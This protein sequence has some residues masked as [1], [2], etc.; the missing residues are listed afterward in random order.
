M[1]IWEFLST[2]YFVATLLLI[3]I[4]AMLGKVVEMIHGPERDHCCKCNNSFWGNH[5]EHI[6]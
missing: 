1:N 6:D 4:V 3:G 2:H 5:D